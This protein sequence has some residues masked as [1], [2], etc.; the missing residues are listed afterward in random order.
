VSPETR[1]ISHTGISASS[2]HAARIFNSL[3]VSVIGFGEALCHSLTQTEGSLV[4]ETIRT[5][6]KAKAF[7]Q[8]SAFIHLPLWA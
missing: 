3:L 1:A 2:E 5:Q 4:F 6:I 8:F 7:L